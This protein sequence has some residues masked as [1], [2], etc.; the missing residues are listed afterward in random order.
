MN[1]QFQEQ[2]MNLRVKTV[3]LNL[4]QT[5]NRRFSSNFAPDVLKFITFLDC[6]FSLFKLILSLPFLSF[7]PDFLLRINNPDQFI[8]QSSSYIIDKIKNSSAAKNLYKCFG[9]QFF[10]FK[11]YEVSRFRDSSLVMKLFFLIQSSRVKPTFLY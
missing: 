6:Y 4:F 11:F 1:L 7:S 10:S 3:F 9:R 2:L 8:I 5:E